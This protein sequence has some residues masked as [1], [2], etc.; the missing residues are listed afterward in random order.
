MGYKPLK[1]KVVGSNGLDY[2]T[3]LFVLL[4]FVETE[5]LGFLQCGFP[6]GGKKNT[7]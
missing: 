7:D 3:S 5:I 1:I 4:P 2:S 6:V